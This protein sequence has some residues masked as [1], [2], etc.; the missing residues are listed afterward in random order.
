MRLGK[1]GMPGGL[2][3]NCLYSLL[4]F[5]INLKLLKKKIKFHKS[6]DKCFG[7][8]I[9]PKFCDNMLFFFFFFIQG[10]FYVKLSKHLVSICSVSEIML[11][12]RYTEVRG[13]GQPTGVLKGQVWM[14]AGWK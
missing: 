9:Y 12:S 14:P 7:H 6:T 8:L 5:S 1:L 10:A 13:E 4:G 11:H 2:Y 3:E